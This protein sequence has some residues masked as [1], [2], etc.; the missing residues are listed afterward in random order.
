MLGRRLV[1]ADE[2]VRGEAMVG[3]ARRRDVGVIDY[4]AEAL[5][6]SNPGQLVFDAA[7]EILAAWPGEARIKSALEKWR[8]E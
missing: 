4:V 2:E 1:D 6:G 3:L 5:K 8:T 7:E